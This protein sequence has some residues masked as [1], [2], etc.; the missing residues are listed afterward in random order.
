MAAVGESYELVLVDGTHD[1]LLDLAAGDPHVVVIKLARNFGQPNA[2]T[3]G[4]EDRALFV[5]THLSY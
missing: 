4:L 1:V 2:T 5:C 3:A